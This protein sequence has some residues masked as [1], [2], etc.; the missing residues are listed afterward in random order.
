MA[1]LNKK[2]IPPVGVDM[3][4]PALNDLINQKKGYDLLSLLVNKSV[5]KGFEITLEAPKI[6]Q[7]V[8]YSI[9]EGQYIYQGAYYKSIPVTSASISAD[10]SYT[11]THGTI[12]ETKLGRR[13]YLIYVDCPTGVVTSTGGE[14]SRQDEVP[15]LTDPA[16]LGSD[17]IA[18]FYITVDKT[19]A[20]FKKI[21]EVTKSN[22]E[23]WEALKDKAGS[24]LV[25][26]FELQIN[27]LKSALEEAN[28]ATFIN[29][30]ENGYYNVFNS[31]KEV[32]TGATSGFT[33][34]G[35]LAKLTTTAGSLKITDISVPGGYKDLDL[36]V[37]LDT[38]LTTL[39][40][41]GTLD[42]DPKVLKAAN[43]TLKANDVIFIDNTPYTVVE[44]LK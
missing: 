5:M 24:D 25:K 9:A 8:Q 33:I 1:K 13:D 18:L 23:I 14:L 31:T 36:Y 20:S 22:S 12:T 37:Y 4:E 34:T 17:K 7:V 40:N 21:Y 6:N 29:Q 28:V 30:Y 26:K 38:N 11:E 32:D 10:V 2:F 39:S 27:D 43:T 42:S 16:T 41:D 19:E 15:K 35:G 44:V 3:L